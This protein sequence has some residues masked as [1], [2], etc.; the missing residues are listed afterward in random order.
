MKKQKTPRKTMLEMHLEARREQ[1]VPSFLPVK[2]LFVASP[3][4]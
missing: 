1:S 3:L 4:R 2:L